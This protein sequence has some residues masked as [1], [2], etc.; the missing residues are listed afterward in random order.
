MTAK[1]K[2]NELVEKFSDYNY[3]QKEDMLTNAK[4]ISL[5]VINEIEYALTQYGE[6]S[7]ELQN[8]NSEF[9]FWESVKD[10]LKITP[11]KK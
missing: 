6:N 9:R 10:E 5:Q 7:M 2:A 4:C 8:M 1:E 3:F 11:T